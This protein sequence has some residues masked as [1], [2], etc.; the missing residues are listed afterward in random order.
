MQLEPK[1]FSRRASTY[2][3]GG[4]FSGELKM[5]RPNLASIFFSAK[6]NRTEVTINRAGV[7]K[8]SGI[9]RLSIFVISRIF[10]KALVPKI[11]IEE[12]DK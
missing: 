5:E 4:N 9:P 1:Q 12:C 2:L 6:L 3:L 8:L 7:I 11:R 10:T